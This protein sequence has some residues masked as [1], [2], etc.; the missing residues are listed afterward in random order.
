MGLRIDIY[1]PI[2]A[3]ARVAGWSAHIIEQLDNNRLMRPRARYV[4]PPSR[5]VVPISDRK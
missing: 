5:L 1:T 2:F 3:M 4:G